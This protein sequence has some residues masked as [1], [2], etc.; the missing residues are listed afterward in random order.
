[1]IAGRI[2]APKA[3]F[4]H[5]AFE[6]CAPRLSGCVRRRASEEKRIPRQRAVLVAADHALDRGPRPRRTPGDE[7]GKEVLLGRVCA[8]GTGGLGAI[9]EKRRLVVRS[10]AL[11]EPLSEGG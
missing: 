1:M 5:T 7:K 2:R 4:D 10:E 6:K 3:K 11:L 9:V 8:S